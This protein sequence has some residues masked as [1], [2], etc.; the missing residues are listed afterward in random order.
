VSAAP[1]WF[2]DSA[3]DGWQALPSPLN[4]PDPASVP[5]YTNLAGVEQPG[6]DFGEI[7]EVQVHR[8]VTLDD[9]ARV[10]EPPPS[11]PLA[12]PVNALAFVEEA[13]RRAT[14]VARASRLHGP[15]HWRQV[16]Q[17]GGMLGVAGVPVDLG[18]LVAFAALH[19]T[20]RLTDG[21]DPEHGPRAAAVA[22]RLRDDGYLDWLDGD[23]FA[24][25][26]EA[27]AT[28]T[29]AERSDHITISACFDADRLTL[30]RIGVC[31]APTLLS[32]GPAISL[33]TLV[34]ATLLNGGP[35]FDWRGLIAGAWA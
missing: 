14:D 1:S 4:D 11:R 31:P 19:D 26:H 35:A 22:G 8:E 29:S 6:F 15:E 28:H 25:L 27:V 24:A 17:V 10:D 2:G 12:D 23:Q 3:A 9:V 20:Q 16:A 34:G 32:S 21:E 5:P 18:V 7:F 33:I 13:E 30:W